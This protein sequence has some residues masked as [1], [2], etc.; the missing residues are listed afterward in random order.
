MGF[1]Q[2][3]NDVIQGDGS[4]ESAVG[5]E[6]VTDNRITNTQAGRRVRAAQASAANTA[7]DSRRVGTERTRFVRRLSASSTVL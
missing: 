1:G 4:I 7:E 6:T 5:L 3:G 2:L